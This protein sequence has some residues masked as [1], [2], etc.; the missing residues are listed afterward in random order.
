MTL[1]LIMFIGAAAA[2][3]VFY[4]R[5]R[6]KRLIYERSYYGL[7]QEIPVLRAKFAAAARASYPD[8]PLAGKCATAMLV[9][10]IAT[11]LVRKFRSTKKS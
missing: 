1:T 8:L 7:A 4:F 5:E 2:G 6:S 3:W 10:I 9:I 11:V